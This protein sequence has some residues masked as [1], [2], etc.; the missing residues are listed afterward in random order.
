MCKPAWKHNNAFLELGSAVLLHHEKRSRLAGTF[1]KQLIEWVKTSR[2][3]PNTSHKAQP[4]TNKG[5]RKESVAIFPLNACDQPPAPVLP[6]SKLLISENGLTA[7]TME[8]LTAFTIG[9]TMQGSRPPPRSPYST[10]GGSP[11][12][13]PM[14]PSPHDGPLGAVPGM[15]PRRRVSPVGS[16]STVQ[17]SLTAPARYLTHLRDPDVQRFLAPSRFCSPDSNRRGGKSLFARPA[18]D[19]SI[20]KA[21]P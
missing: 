8:Q 2:S 7:A 10:Q 19:L 1:P 4:H 5:K 3:G 17:R 15:G 11:T 21:T 9:F 14:A 20:K 13:S 18:K 16:L 12:N 6:P